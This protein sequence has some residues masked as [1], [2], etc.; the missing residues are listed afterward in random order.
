VGEAVVLANA[1]GHVGMTSPRLEALA[2]AA[3][4]AP[5]TAF[6]VVFEPGML[7]DVLL[8]DERVMSLDDVTVSS[9]ELMAD[10]VGFDVALPPA[11]LERTA[12]SAGRAVVSDVVLTFWSTWP[13]D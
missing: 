8:A 7:D 5:S 6:R 2:L 4:P 3:L 13:V 12:D 11:R 10:C 1:T 9:V